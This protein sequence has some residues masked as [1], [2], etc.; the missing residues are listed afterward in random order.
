[1]NEEV[2]KAKQRL[3]VL[4]FKKDR[5][6]DEEKEY[7]ELRERIA[8]RRG[9]P[10]RRIDDTVGANNTANPETGEKPGDELNPGENGEDANYKAAVVAKMQDNIEKNVILGKQALTMLSLS[11]NIF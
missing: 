1:M 4:A 11:L 6:E 10:F 2:E 5:S 3:R 7:K 8:S 9:D